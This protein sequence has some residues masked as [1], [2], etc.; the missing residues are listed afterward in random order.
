MGTESRKEKVAKYNAWYRATHREE[1]ALYRK[2]VSQVQHAKNREAYSRVRMEF[3]EMY[4]GKCTCCGETLCE[5]LTIEHKLG[6]SGTER[7]DTSAKA[8]RKATQNYSPDIYEI[9]CMNCNHAKGKYGYCPH[10]K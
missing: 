1:I 9:L 10:N 4:G 2:K 6:Q 3:L 5:F 7:R 8:Y